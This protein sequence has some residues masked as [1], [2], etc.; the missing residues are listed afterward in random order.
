MS[1]TKS[2]CG[3]TIALLWAVALWCSWECIGLSEDGAYLLMEVV[4]RETF[5]PYDSNPRYFS[6]LLSQIPVVAALSTG[7]DDF[8]WLA[9][10]Y[11]LGLYA[12]PLTL[13]TMALLR[14][15]DD[16]VLAASV[17]A[18]IAMVFLSTSFHIVA[19]HNAGYAIAVSGAIWIVTADRLRI[20]D[21]VV[22]AATALL[23]MRTY[24]A[25]VYLGPVLAA[26]TLWAIWRAPLRP[27]GPC[28]LYLV[29]AGL[30]LCGMA[31]AA[32]SILNYDEP[33]Y[34]GEVLREAREFRKYL[35]FDLCVGAALVVV[36]W[37]LLRPRE[38]LGNRLYWAA[39]GLLVMLALSPLLV[40]GNVLM[41]P[42][43]A[44]WHCVGR[45]AAGPVVVAI[46]LFVW[47]Y[48]ADV[49]WKPAAYSI[50]RMPAAARRLLGFACLM[51]LATLPWY[52]VLA[53][54]YIS[55]LEQVR[56]SIAARSGIIPFEET[57]LP[58][59]P[60]LLQGDGWQ[61][62][63]LSLVLRSKPT[64]GVIAPPKGLE[65]YQPFP[66]S[67]LPELGRFMW[68]SQS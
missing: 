66:L 15:R 3:A 51:L 28:L 49:R 63:P 7:V 32:D 68:R 44:H 5:L 67:E 53:H 24:E 36:G 11:S 16:A 25:F 10:L 6:N 48:K 21:G 47:I 62:V 34:I 40:L 23:A 61:L 19:E 33:Q 2:A 54:L 45:T 9:R 56:I 26:M 41:H 29:A 20:V 65:K 27:L 42:P 59:H 46:M 18:A 8:H 1:S 4:R 13:Y 37:S 55:Y 30:F 64:D 22:L 38:L 39:G 58:S 52:L 60:R 17:I 31:I 43:H 57:T 35:P 12:V 14:V 50:L